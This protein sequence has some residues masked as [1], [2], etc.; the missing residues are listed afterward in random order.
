MN[1]R[2]TEYL[3]IGFELGLM[4][5]NQADYCRDQLDLIRLV[6]WLCQ[7]K[8]YDYLPSDNSLPRLTAAF[9]A[10]SAISAIPLCSRLSSAAAV[11]PLGEVT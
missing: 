8:S 6:N 7:L 10:L 2:L 11:V 9:T 1:C 3:K 5:L 4:S